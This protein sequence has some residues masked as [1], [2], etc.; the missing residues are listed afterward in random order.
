[1]KFKVP[2]SDTALSYNAGQPMGTYSSWIAFTLTH[3]LVVYYC[4]LLEGL[5]DFDQYIILGDDIVIKNDKVA[6]RYMKVISKLGVS[7]SEQKSHVSY[8][9]YEFA[10]RWF[11]A[12]KEITG[13][14]VKGIISNF[15][16]P[17]IVSTILYDYFKI[18]NNLYLSRIPL[19]KLV[20][21]LYYKFF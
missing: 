16:N 3:H 9:T 20:Q 4:A 6:K 19:C 5:D 2:G 15:K 1:M 10:K 14:P 18:K 21:G 8:D 7:I 13:I 11:K 17:Y 12:G